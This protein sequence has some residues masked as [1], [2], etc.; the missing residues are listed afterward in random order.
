MSPIE[1][2][3]KNKNSFTKNRYLSSLFG[4]KAKKRL[5]LLLLP[6]NPHP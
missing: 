5:A 3:G 4:W 6:H 2:A 1:S